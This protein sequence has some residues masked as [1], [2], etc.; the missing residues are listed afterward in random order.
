MLNGSLK[1]APMLVFRMRQPAERLTT[2]PVRVA[3][4]S[5]RIGPDTGPGKPLDTGARFGAL[6]VLGRVMRPAGEKR[7]GHFYRCRCDCGEV[8][9]RQRD[10]IVTRDYATCGCGIQRNLAGRSKKPITIGKP[11]G[12]PVS[13]SG[14]RSVLIKHRLKA[15]ASPLSAA[16]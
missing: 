16:L 15:S 5:A 3:P 12:R 1:T 4:M 10:T 7:S 6:T 8:V 13:N 2:S 9:V 11:W 14:N